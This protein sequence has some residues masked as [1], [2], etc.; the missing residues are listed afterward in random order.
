MCVYYAAQNQFERFGRFLELISRFEFE[1]RHCGTYFWRIRILGVFKVQSHAMWPYMCLCCGL[2]CADAIPS[3]MLWCPW[4]HVQI[5]IFIDIVICERVQICICICTSVC[6]LNVQVYIFRDLESGLSRTK[7]VWTWKMVNPA[8]EGHTLVEARGDTDVHIVRYAWRKRAIDQPNNLAACFPLDRW[9]WTALSG[10]ANDWRNWG[11]VVLNLFSHLK[12]G[13]IQKFLW[14]TSEARV[15]KQNW[16]WPLA[17]RV[18]IQNVPV[19]TGTTRTCFNTC[20]RGAGIHGD[21][22]NVH[23]E[24]FLKP[25]TF[26]LRFFSV[27]QHTQT[28][29]H[30]THTHHNHQQHHVHN[31]THH[32]TQHTTS[33]GDRER[34]QRKRG[35]TRRRQEK[36]KE[37]RR[38]EKKREYE[39][40]ERSERRLEERRRKTREETR[41]RRERKWKRK[42]ETRWKRR[43][44]MKGKMKEKMKR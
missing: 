21:V 17:S 16:R 7:S 42:I 30:Q 13:K 36:M 19:C 20:A 38:E 40:Q 28:H 4:R 32:I 25:N 39:R 37:E 29:T 5:H 27:P 15:G 33:H 44:K 6:I 8:W 41:W 10:K 18:W 11:H 31:D 43:E 12:T 22:S 14:W 34:R 1:F 35:K 3:R 2:F 23:T 24:A 9:N 26:F